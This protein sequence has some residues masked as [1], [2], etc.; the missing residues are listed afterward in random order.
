MQNNFYDY[1][2][3]PKRQNETITNSRTNNNKFNPL[4]RRQFDEENNIPMKKPKRFEDNNLNKRYLTPLPLRYQAQS[5]ETY[6]TKNFSRVTN[7]NT[8]ISNKINNTNENNNSSNN[9]AFYYKNL[10]HQTK[11]NLNK[12]KQKNE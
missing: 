6:S 7:D 10:Y 9:D 4:Q 1:N 8:D 12:E 3:I 5:N 2:Q 11:N